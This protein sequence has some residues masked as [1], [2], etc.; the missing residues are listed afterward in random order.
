MKSEEL[1]QLIRNRFESRNGTYNQCVV[2]EQVPDGTGGNQTRWID[3]AA[4]QMW[5]SKGLTR[6]AFE[7]KVS[8]QDFINELRHPEK[9]QWC[10]DCFHEF[11]FVAPKEVIQIEEL[12]AGAGWMYP[13]GKGLATA[14]NA[15]RNRNPKLDDHLLS[16]FMRAAYKE[17]QQA[18]KVESKKIIDND[19][20]C[21]DAK[22]VLKGVE[23][24]LEK[25][26]KHTYLYDLP[27][28]DVV[29]ERLEEATLDKEVQ[30]DRDQI[31]AILNHFQ[32]SIQDL[33]SV[34]ALV[35]HRSLLE[36]DETGR[37][38]ARQYGGVDEFTLDTMRRVNGKMT[39][40]EKR[41]TEL[42][43]IILNWGKVWE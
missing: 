40:S 41:S 9:H 19:K 37:Y 24:F 17:I 35:A 16:A 3:V 36:K 4:F 25:R 33:F 22:I 1:V 11:W 10:F 6:S 30:R 32:S 13:R 31:Q 2:L 39:D 38:I 20:G 14:R 27:G 42:L 12:P 15:V 21:Q 23:A 5:E 8:R 43:E 26:G 28:I 34:F 18:S 29:V 7:V